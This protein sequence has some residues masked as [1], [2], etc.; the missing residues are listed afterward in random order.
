[1]TDE[2][3]EAISGT[4][5]WDLSLSCG[6]VRW[7]RMKS[8]SSYEDRGFLRV[9]SQMMIREQA[10]AHERPAGLASGL[11]CV[12]QRSNP[13]DLAARTAVLRHIIL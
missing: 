5:I 9:V 12:K 8:N 6:S 13:L 2:R 7:L 3:R 11:G 4:W 1:M 10:R